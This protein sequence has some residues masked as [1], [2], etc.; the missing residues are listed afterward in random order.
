M[1]FILLSLFLAISLLSFSQWQN[2]DSLYGPLPASVKVFVTTQRIDTAPFKAYYVIA[3]LKDN[4]LDYTTDTTLDRR[5][6]PSHF[7]AKNNNPLLV[8]NGT[9]FSFQ[10]NRNLNAVI[11]KGKLLAGNAQTVAGR[12]KDTL[13]YRHTFPSAIG[14]NKKRKADVAWLYTDTI[15]K[16]T[17]AAQWPL[18]PL[19]DSTAQHSLK[20]IV[21]NTS[22]IAGH[23]GKLSPT[24]QK[25]KVQT[26][27]GGGPVLVQNGAVQ[28]TNNE[29]LKFAGKAINDKHP[30]T[31][32]GYTAENKLVIL[33][34]EG[35]TKES[36][37]ASLLQTAQL[38]K[39]I[40]CVEALNLDGGGS[41]CLL[42]NGKETIRPSDKEGQRPVPAV[43][44][45]KKR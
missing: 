12:G 16:K 31:A 25:W 41:S 45:I 28:V 39:D 42:V 11:R 18:P 10:T 7:Y 21:T 38:L 43:F 24:L 40:G 44:L 37:G 5:A 13:T 19:K 8:V 3:D 4:S 22:L 29:E 15:K 20:E 27:I 30:R 1:K 36:G 26:A 6:T 23:S 9:F 32:M 33:V 35:R 17:Y 2:V 34:I 14:I